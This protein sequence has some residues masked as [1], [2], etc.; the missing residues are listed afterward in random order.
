MAIEG[1]DVTIAK[2]ANE[3]G[4]AEAAEIAGSERQA[5]GRVEF[6]MRG[7]TAQQ[8]P[9][10]IK[11]VDKAPTGTGLVI[12][13]GRVLKSIRDKE[14]SIYVLDAK[15]SITL[16]RERTIAGQHVIGE[17][18]DK[19]PTPVKHLHGPEAEIGRVNKLLTRVTADGQPLVN[20]TR[21][22]LRT[23]D[24]DD[25]VGQVDVAIPASDGTVF[26]GKDENASSGS[27]I[28]ADP[29]I[30]RVSSIPIIKDVSG[31]G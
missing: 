5:P 25:G 27:A 16:A 12:M 4:V 11:D 10:G 17:G 2:V 23:V 24:L 19:L 31:W 22:H 8:I 20:G 29:E 7:E 26:R 6:A 18:T 28:L 1:I 3:Q 13:L 14:V 30:V 9:T 15:G 21:I